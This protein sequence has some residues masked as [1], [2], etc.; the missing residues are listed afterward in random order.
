MITLEK[1]REKAGM[2]ISIVIGIALLAFV[3]NADTLATARAIFSSDNDMGEIAGTTVS[4]EEFENMLTYNTN[5]FKLMYM[6]A[7]QE[8][9][10]GEA[11][12]ENLRNE[13]WR[14][15]VFKYMFGKEYNK[16]GLSVSDAELYDLTLGA[17]IHPIVKQYFGDAD[18]ATIS[19]FV[20]SMDGNAKILWLDIEKRIKDEQLYARY[21]KLEQKSNYV[22][23]LEVEQSLEGEKQN[24]D[25]SYVLKDYSSVADSLISYKESDLKSYYNKHKDEYKG[26][27]ARDVEFVAFSVVPS[28]TDFDK[29]V[30]KMTE[31]KKKM[32][33]IP[34]ADFPVFVSLNSEEKFDGT[35]RKKGELPAVLDSVAFNGKAGT[36]FPFYQEGNTYMLSGIVGFKNFPDSV[37]AQHILF[38]PND[39]GNVDSVFNLLK[40]GSDFAA[41]AKLFSTDPAAASGGDLGWFT[42]EKMVKPFSDSCFFNPPGSIM[43]VVTEFGVHIVKVNAA[44][45]STRKIQL[46]TV[47]KTVKPSKTTYQNYFAQANKI[48]A[49]SEGNLKKFRTV[50][51]EEG[52]FPYTEVNVGLENKFVGQFRNASNLIRWM[53]SAKEGDVSGVLEIDDRKTYVIAALTNIKN[54]GT[55][56]F[57]KVRTQILPKVI[58]EKKADYL[59]AEMSKSKSGLGNIDEIASKLGGSVISVTPAV[60]FNTSYIP[61]LRLPEYKLLGA[62]TSSPV[63]QVSEPLAGESGVYLYT[64]TNIADNPQA[65]TPEALKS[66]LES[67]VFSDPYSIL[68]ANLK[69]VDNRGKFY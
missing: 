42:P 46:A 23:A 44:K 53:Y 61:T 22:T 13:A 43:K 10:S 27:R 60:N 16:I 58:A 68:T 45:G 17:N 36:V 11:I 20:Q 51:A 49:Q 26:K 32:D 21:S 63:N 40:S 2:F 52:V 29:V 62:V 6:L 9:P 66:R 57:E 38:S 19:N 55:L 69:I 48:A 1:L 31:L 14:H 39:L 18:R 67:N 8:A 59:V 33:T 56:P 35:Y 37:K 4:G 50:C 41:M 12:T 30:E 25:F 28:A 3:V 54:D 47:K 34:A 15:L 5:I 24:V 64:V 7:G 65:Q